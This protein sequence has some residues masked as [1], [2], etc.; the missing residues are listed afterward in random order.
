MHQRL[1]KEIQGFS[2]PL[3]EAWL[4]IPTK[5]TMLWVRFQEPCLTCSQ[6]RHNSLKVCELAKFTKK[7]PFLSQ[8]LFSLSGVAVR[9]LQQGCILFSDRNESKILQTINQNKQTKPWDMIFTICLL[10]RTI[11]YCTKIGLHM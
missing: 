7:T 4:C 8:Q 6:L 5:M 1:I 3:A 11:F 9:F 2:K 10:E